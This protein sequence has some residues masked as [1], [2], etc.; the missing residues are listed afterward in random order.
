MIDRKI[1]KFLLTKR[2]KIREFK[3]VETVNVRFF[4]PFSAGLI[5]LRMI[6]KYQTE[7]F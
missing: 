1:K 2:N 5:P 6:F 3:T 7:Q 4:I